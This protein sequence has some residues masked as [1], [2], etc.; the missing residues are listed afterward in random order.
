M[1]YT[2]DDNTLYAVLIDEDNGEAG[3]FLDYTGTA[4]GAV[5][6]K[7]FNMRYVNAISTTG[8][9]R[10]FYIGTPDN[11]L[12]TEGGGITVGGVTFNVS[13]KRGESRR[14]PRAADT[15]QTDGDPT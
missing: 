11:T 3:G 12:L 10:K 13:S 4:D 1:N 6:P 14:L 15:G 9:Q 7:Y 8:I 5:L 2:A